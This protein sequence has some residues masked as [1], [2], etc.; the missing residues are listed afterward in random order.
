VAAL[1]LAG[2]L[3]HELHAH[4]RLVMTYEVPYPLPLDRPAVTVSVLEAQVRRWAEQAGWE[5]AGE[6]YLCRDKWQTLKR[7][8]RPGSLLVVGGRTHWWSSGAQ[9]LAHHL[10]KD[11]YQVIFAELR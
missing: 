1:R 7:L 6:I 2:D 11:G 9:A 4:L 8:L 10:E 3:T 5:V